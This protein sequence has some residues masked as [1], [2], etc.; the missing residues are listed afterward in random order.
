MV[1]FITVLLVVFAENY[2]KPDKVGHGCGG[3]TLTS[4]A[5]LH[6]LDPYPHQLSH[7]RHSDLRHH[8]QSLH[9]SATVGKIAAERNQRAL[10]EL[11]IKTGNGEH[12]LSRPLGLG[13]PLFCFLGLS[14][15]AT[16]LC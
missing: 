15:H 12:C 13:W 2:I 11:A 10:L 5:N 8:N 7:Q 14:S 4:L 6:F 16:V 1:M 3:S 9:M